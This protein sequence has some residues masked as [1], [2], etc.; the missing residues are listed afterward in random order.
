MKLKK[1]LAL[2][3]TVI[4]AAGVLAGCGGD[5]QKKDAASNAKPPLKVATNATF[6]P[7]EFKSE[8]D[9]D[10]KGYEIDMI[11]AVGKEMSREV[12]F[13]NI[14]FNGI[15]PVLQSGEIDAAASGMTITK[16]RAEKVL[17]AAPFYES[18]LVI[19]TKKD[20]P[21]QSIADL[22]DKQVAVQMGTIASD[23][24]TNQG[25]TTKQFDHNAEAL[26][27]L[28]VGGSEAVITDKPVA[29]YYAAKEGKGEV[30]VIEI[31]DS[32]KQYLAFAMNKKDVQLQKDLNAAIAKLKETG[33][34]QKIYKKWFNTVPGELPKAAEETM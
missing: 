25:L 19:L 4:A 6:V 32:T 15:I 11:R 23:Y 29:D 27:E 24:A 30:K 5:T 20:S 18:K 17:F 12:E 28:K 8:E 2:T 7:F 16:E 31:P 33:E 21:I 13:Q 3:L 34:F 14:P 9:S 22:K 10:Y 1:Y 26:M